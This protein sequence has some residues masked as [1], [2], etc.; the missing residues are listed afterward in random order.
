[1]DRVVLITDSM[2]GPPAQNR[3]AIALAEELSSKY[4]VEFY[5][6][7]VE[8]ESRE[9]VSKFGFRTIRSECGY[10]YPGQ[11][12]IENLI[13]RVDW[14]WVGDAVV[15]N[16]SNQLPVPSHVY[17]FQGFLSEFSRDFR[18]YWQG[19][20]LRYKLAISIIG[21]P[22][23]WFVD[24]VWAGALRRS[25]FV[26]ANSF[27]AAHQLRRWGV[28]YVDVVTP[29]INRWLIDEY[30]RVEPQGDREY[31]LVHVGK[32][33]VYPWLYRAIKAVVGELRDKVK[34]VFIF[35]AKF[36]DV[37]RW[38]GKKLYELHERYGACVQYVMNHIAYIRE[39]D[40]PR[41]YGGALLTIFTYNHEPY[42]Y[43]PI[44]SLMAGVPV[45]SIGPGVDGAFH[46]PFHTAQRYKHAAWVDPDL[47]ED[48]VPE[49][50]KEWGDLTVPIEERQ[51]VAL[52]HDPR[53]Y[54]EAMDT[55]ISRA[56]GGS[57]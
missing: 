11:A 24:R 55:Y 35:G 48:A 32:E 9:L 38:F 53:A 20:Q 16:F 12:T 21:H 3:P 42:G 40:M 34:T 29:P 47:I 45:I 1:M 33:T 44:E 10:K 14:G 56:L 52:D 31:V 50:I 27:L 41:L 57:E 18:R 19:R 2:A 7:C 36:N 39:R 6:P 54:A 5:A 8:G 26:V 46:G 4:T 13:P 22:V 51:G 15:V 25:R 49:I 28:R 17:Y 30:L 37:P 23:F 43:V